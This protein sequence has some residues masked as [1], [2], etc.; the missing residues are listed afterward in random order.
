LREN[1][2]GRRQDKYGACDECLPVS[3]CSCHGRLPA[4]HGRAIRAATSCRHQTRRKC[5]AQGRA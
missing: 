4:C 5:P 3:A 2:G 1:R